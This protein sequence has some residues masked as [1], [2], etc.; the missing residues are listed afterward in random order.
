MEKFLDLHFGLLRYAIN[1]VII[2]LYV[3]ETYHL[4]ELF[5]INLKTGYTYLQTVAEFKLSGNTTTH[6]TKNEQR[7]NLYHTNT[8]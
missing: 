8:Y 4:T 2:P 5:P 3:V 6:I 7:N 1:Q